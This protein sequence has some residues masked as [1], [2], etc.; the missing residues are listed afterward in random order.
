MKPTALLSTLLLGASLGAATPNI[1]FFLV[2][3]LGGGRKD[4]SKDCSE[5]GA[6]GWGRLDHGGEDPSFSGMQL[7]FESG[8]YGG[9]W[10]RRILRRCGRVNHPA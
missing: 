1:V 6:K 4:E 5:A 2:D 3:D 10:L 7:V 9:K 8:S